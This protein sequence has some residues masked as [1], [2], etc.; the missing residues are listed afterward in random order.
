MDSKALTKTGFCNK[1]I[2]NVTDNDM[3]C[4]YTSKSSNKN[5]Y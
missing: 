1:E 3:K 2:D 5:K 4:L